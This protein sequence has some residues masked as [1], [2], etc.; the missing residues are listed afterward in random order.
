[1]SLRLYTSLVV[2]LIFVFRL[3]LRAGTA[4]NKLDDA[5]S[6]DFRFSTASAIGLG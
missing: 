3:L 5:L 6:F 4:S 1:M 2:A